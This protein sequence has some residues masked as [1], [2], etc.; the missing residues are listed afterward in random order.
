[1]VNKLHR[2][3]CHIILHIWQKNP[4]SLSVHC[5][6]LIIPSTVL[7]PVPSYKNRKRL[8]VLSEIVE[9]TSC[10][11]ASNKH[12][13]FKTTF[14]IFI[15]ITHFLLQKISEGEYEGW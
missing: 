15:F 10:K 7:V 5:P 2:K 4:G 11:L 8:F 1:M 6:V 13:E 9:N 3:G 12:T 14:Y